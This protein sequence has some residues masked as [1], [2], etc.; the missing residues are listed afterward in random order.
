MV[1]Y[2]NKYSCNTVG[3][4]VCEQKR[5]K[6][7]HVKYICMQQT[8]VFMHVHVFVMCVCVFEPV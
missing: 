3:L 6:G 4:Q 2:A 1:K 7:F 8:A 5:N